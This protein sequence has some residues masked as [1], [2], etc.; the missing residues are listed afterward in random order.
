MMDIMRWSVRDALFDTFGVKTEING[1][2]MY[3]R[4]DYITVC[5]TTPNKLNEL[6]WRIRIAPSATFDRWAN[7]VVIDRC[8]TTNDELVIYLEERDTRVNVY[9]ELYEALSSE[10]EEMRSYAEDR[11]FD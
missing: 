4:D 8:F 1:N 2:I 5:V 6:G 10:V 3:G 11:R 7:S 9:K